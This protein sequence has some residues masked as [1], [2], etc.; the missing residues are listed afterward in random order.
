MSSE[1]GELRCANCHRPLDATDRFCRECGL[2]TLLQ[3]QAQRAVPLDAPGVA[4]A[5]RGAEVMPD[6][7]P[8]VR[9]AT[10]V[11][12]PA[13]PTNELT[14]GGVVRVTSPTLATQMAAS[15]VVMVVVI[16][17]LAAVGVVLLVLAFR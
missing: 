13:E 1:A 17:G 15:T 16:V 10:D 12:R 14:T 5:R 8:I 7:Q 4:E 6:P 3:A 2:P 11:T 9:P